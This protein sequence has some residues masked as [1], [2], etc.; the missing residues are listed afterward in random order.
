MAHHHICGRRI[1]I[2]HGTVP[3]RNSPS[4]AGGTEQGMSI[5][6]RKG[7]LQNGNEETGKPFI[8]EKG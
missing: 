8:D 7:A 1:S 2:F 4:Y 6:D 5:V 3:K